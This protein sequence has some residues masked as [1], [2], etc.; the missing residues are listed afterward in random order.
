MLNPIPKGKIL[1]ETIHIDHL[2]PINKGNATKK[3]VFVII[4]FT[5]FVK[6]FTTKTTSD[7]EVIDYMINYVKT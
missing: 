7:K 3:Y 2:G 5:K 4:D 1:F 6:L